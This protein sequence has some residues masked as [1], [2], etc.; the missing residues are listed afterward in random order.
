MGTCSLWG[1]QPLPMLC[2]SP[3]E[4]LAFT[5]NG[6]ELPFSL[7]A[8]AFTNKSKLSKEKA[9]LLFMSVVPL[10]VSS[11]VFKI[12]IKKKKSLFHLNLLL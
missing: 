7:D 9:L 1:K 8:L 11:E 12:V 5:G 6:R 2:S 4:E 3:A 10:Y